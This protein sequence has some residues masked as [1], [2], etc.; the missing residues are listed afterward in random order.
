MA[1]A[2]GGA[3][4]VQQAD[5]SDYEL[6]TEFLAN[7]DITITHVRVWAGA[8]ETNVTNRRGRIWSTAGGQLGIATLSDDLPTG[9]SQY[10]LDAPVE[11]LAGQRFVV[12]YSTG[13]NY[14]ALLDALAGAS[15][16][17]G[18]GN[19]TAL[20]TA[21]ATNGNGVFNG[22]PGSF[23]TTSPGAHPFYGADVVYDVGIGGNTA[24]VIVEAT[25]VAAG[26][27]VTA[28]IVATDAET[29]VGATYR[30]D[31]GDGSLVTAT[32]AVSA[33]HTYTT[34][35]TYG[36]LLSVTDADGLAD[37]AA[38]GIDVLVPDAGLTPLDTTGIID[39]VVAHAAGTGLFEHV[40][41]AEPLAA[42]QNELTAAV[43]AQS[44]EPAPA[45][46]GLA[47]TSIRVVLSVRVYTRMIREP[48][49]AIDPAVVDAVDALMAAYSG[50]FTLGGQVRQVDLLGAHGQPM[51]ADAGYLTQDGTPFRVVTITLPLI[52]NDVWEQAP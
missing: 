49:D 2:W 16:N 23:P 21:S 40:N 48:R 50:D 44:I 22:T 26:P 11:R 8:G 42:P 9:W 19:V 25:V 47:T 10:A 45:G 3:D 24:P 29:L 14:G 41:R 37:Y 32:S 13:G 27:A 17:S 28:T 33:Q 43:W 12:S 7:A 5:A 1:T 18:D 31:W 15:V 34:S 36:V 52:C 39:A 46:S 30:F 4:P 38:V 51:R 6:G 35:G 20:G